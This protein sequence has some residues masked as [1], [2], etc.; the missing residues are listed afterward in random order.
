MPCLEETGTSQLSLQQGS[1][2]SKHTRKRFYLMHN[3]MSA[4]LDPVE[5]EIAQTLL[6]I[7]KMEQ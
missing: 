1:K 7:C 5:K 6:N 4:M 2:L 3:L